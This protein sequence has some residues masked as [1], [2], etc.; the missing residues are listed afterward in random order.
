MLCVTNEFLFCFYSCKK[1][2]SWFLFFMSNVRAKN[3]FFCVV[4]YIFFVR[5]IV[6]LLPII[7]MLLF[8]SA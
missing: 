4:D 6:F 5:D 3:E 1:T 8:V 7:Q 2:C